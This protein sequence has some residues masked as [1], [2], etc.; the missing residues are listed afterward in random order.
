MAFHKS[1]SAVLTKEWLCEIE[2]APADISIAVEGT[3]L[4]ID[5]VDVLPENGG[6]RIVLL[7]ASYPGSTYDAAAAAAAAVIVDRCSQ[8]LAAVR[9]AESIAVPA[10]GYALLAFGCTDEEA[11]RF[12]ALFKQGDAVKLRLNGD[13]AAARELAAA[14]GVQP[15]LLLDSGMLET[16]LEPSFSLRGRVV[17]RSQERAYS[18]SVNGSAVPVGSDGSFV[19]DVPLRAGGN[20][21]EAALMENGAVRD[22]A[23]SFVFYKQPANSAGSASA[24]E[25]SGREVFLWVEQ[26]HNMLSFQSGQAVQTMLE[27]AKSAGITSIVFDVKGVEGFAAYRKNGLTGRPYVSEMTS[28]DRQGANPEQ[29]L[30]EL[31][32][33]HGHTSGLRVYAAL[34]V[35]AEGSFYRNQFALP[36]SR[37]QAWEQRV[38]RPE[39]GGGLLLQRNAAYAR[40]GRA[41]V[42]F[43]NPANEEVRDFELRGIREIIEGYDVD[44][45][46]LDRCRYDNEFSDFGGETKAAFERYL[47]ARGKRLTS[48]PHDV[49]AYDG[50]GTRIEGP[51]FAEWW[52]FRAHVIE[53]FVAETRRLIDLHNEQRSTN[54]RLAAYVGSWYELHYRYGVNWASPNTDYDDRLGFPEDFLY[55]DEYAAAG[56]TD[57]LDFLMIGTYQK[58]VR[59][60]ERYITLAK[61]MT[62]G[63]LPVYAGVAIAALQDPALRRRIMSGCRTKSDGLMLFDH[64]HIRDWSAF[65]EDLTES[66]NP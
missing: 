31:F 16:A 59:D 19:C 63:E 23:V 42:Q 15:A 55:T 40:N 28:P 53:S 58:T 56:Y 9:P 38:Y 7:T 17:R 52:A 14:C 44:G 41:T 47:A 49:F 35:F 33:R 30:L 65:A 64:C 57:S 22:A 12:A 37:L 43:V 29:D 48:W 39:D 18:L 8:V 62:N 13:I 5:A 66:G 60:V 45:I 51:L 11:A 54:V 61:L 36:E 24:A 2:A 4:R 6:S 46:V 20:S 1:D 26:G 27:K 25:A 34:N 21:V 32:V 10:G 3:R 50:R